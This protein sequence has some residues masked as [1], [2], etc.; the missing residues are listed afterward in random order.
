MTIFLKRHRV[1]SV[2][3][4][5]IKIL[6]GLFVFG[7]RLFQF[8]DVEADELFVADD[9]EGRHAYSMDVKHFLEGLVVADD[10]VVFELY[11]LALQ[12][13]LELVACRTGRLGIDL[14]VSHCSPPS[15]FLTLI[16]YN[17]NGFWIIDI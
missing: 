4:D 1:K 15:G 7:E 9:D 2:I 13:L 14:N 10:V 6:N 16:G 11:V 5:F 3:M 12:V 17:L 8:F